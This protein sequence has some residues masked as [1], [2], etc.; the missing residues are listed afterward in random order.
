MTAFA[1]VLLPQNDGESGAAPLCVAAAAEVLL[2]FPP[3]VITGGYS[4]MA[5]FRA[6]VS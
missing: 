1:L 3:C 2:Q 6:K 4:S 5:V